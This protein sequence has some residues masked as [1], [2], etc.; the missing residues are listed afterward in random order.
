VLAVYLLAVT[1][2][3]LPIA[4]VV[5]WE[6]AKPPSRDPVELLADIYPALPF[7]LAAEMD[8]VAERSDAV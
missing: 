2:H 8:M 4:S 7:N 6:V 3:R 1:T 5:E